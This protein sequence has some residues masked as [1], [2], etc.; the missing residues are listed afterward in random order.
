MFSGG[1]ERDYWHEMD[2]WKESLHSQAISF[3]GRATTLPFDERL[4]IQSCIQHYVKH[5]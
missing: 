1:I 4:Y 2:Y 5:K 3:S